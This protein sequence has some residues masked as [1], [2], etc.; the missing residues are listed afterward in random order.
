MP[1][2]TPTAVHLDWPLCLALGAAVAGA[3]Q[4]PEKPVT[5]QETLRGT[6]SPEREWWH[7]LHDDLSVQFLPETRSIRGDV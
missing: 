5:R 1:R 3:P 7:V 6:I 4:T 2:P